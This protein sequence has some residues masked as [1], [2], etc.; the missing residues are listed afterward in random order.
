D[1]G[2]RRHEEARSAAGLHHLN[3]VDM[4]EVLDLPT[5]LY[6]VYEYNPGKSLRHILQEKGK[7]SLVQVRDI[8]IPVCKALEHAHHRE[9]V[10]GGL[11]PER[12][13]VTN[14]RYVQ[15]SDFVL[16]RTTGTGSEPY[17]APEAKRGEPRTVSD[18]YSMGMCFFEMLTGELPNQSAYEPDPVIAPI[19]EKA[20]D[21]DYRSRL[22]SAREF[23]ALLQRL[24]DTYTIPEP[25]AEK[26]AAEAG[27]A[28]SVEGN[29]PGNG[30]KGDSDPEPDTGR[31]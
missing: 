7:L 31:S 12:I 10:H 4:Y 18:I 14:Q 19:I 21:L 16:A 1:E 24:P 27:P 6:V 30:A 13:H 9:I 15:V 29:E 26:P 5:G 22:S 23:L 28:E 8:L 11:S 2:S 3:V 17:A 20:L 25:R